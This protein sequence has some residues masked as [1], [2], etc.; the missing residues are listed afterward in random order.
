MVRQTGT[1]PAVFGFVMYQNQIIHAIIGFKYDVPCIARSEELRGHSHTAM[2]SVLCA[3]C[4]D[5]SS[6]PPRD[7]DFTMRG[8]SCFNSQTF[9]STVSYLTL[10]QMARFM[11]PTWA[12]LGLVGPRWAH[13]GLT[14]LAI[15]DRIL[16]NGIVSAFA[17]LLASTAPWPAGWLGDLLVNRGLL[18]MTNVRKLFYAIG[19][20]HSSHHI[21]MAATIQH[22]KIS[23]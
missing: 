2:H 13:V 21:Q 18:S 16:Q 10:S 3:S 20:Y 12:H 14:N 5:W 8:T 11:W 6:W 4:T 19:K 7:F 23:M 15:R 1:L 9:P 22:K 17:Y